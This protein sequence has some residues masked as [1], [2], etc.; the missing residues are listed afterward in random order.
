MSDEP[1]GRATMPCRRCDEQVVIAEAAG[2]Q[3][4]TLCRACAIETA[5]P[6]DVV[7]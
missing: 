1:S 7:L 5:E 2:R 3:K 6:G 4:E